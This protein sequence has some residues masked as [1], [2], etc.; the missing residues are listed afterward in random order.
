MW[1]QKVREWL[2]REERDQA[3][4]A[5]HAK[6]SESY[7]S[8]LMTGKVQPSLETLRK[9]EEVMGM[10]FG[11]LMKLREPKVPAGAQVEEGAGA[12]AGEGRGGVRDHPRPKWRRSDGLHDC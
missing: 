4:L 2:E 8:N 3:Y 1:R 12:G 9:L 6:I 10:E 11:E 7:V 5:R